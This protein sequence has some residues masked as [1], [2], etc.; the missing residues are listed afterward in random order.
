MAKIYGFDSINDGEGSLKAIDGS[1][2]EAGDIAFGVHN[3]GGYSQFFSFVLMDED[4][5]MSEELPY[6]VIPS[7]NPGNKF[8]QYS[9]IFLDRPDI[10]FPEENED[11]L[12]GSDG[13]GYGY[14]GWNRISKANFM[15]SPGPI[16][17][18]EAD[19]VR[20]FMETVTPNFNQHTGEINL[21]YED[22][23][24]CI[25][26]VPIPFTSGHTGAANVINL[27]EN[28]RPGSSFLLHIQ[29][30]EHWSDE[31]EAQLY[32]SPY[33]RVIFDGVELRGYLQVTLTDADPSGLHIASFVAIRDPVEDQ[34]IWVGT[35][36]VGEWEEKGGLH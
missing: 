13:G 9:D 7:S 6:V 22:A 25:F 28:P 12:I 27:P 33:E 8:W 34:M 14:W 11:L 1:T 31:I 29:K 3:V 16:G 19:V 23:S 26:Q 21:S 20:S 35:S 15:G 10:D 30:S 17:T 24:G 5:S 18:G 32:G 4:W 36:M 2:L